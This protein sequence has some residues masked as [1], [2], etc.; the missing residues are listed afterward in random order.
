MMANTT[1]QE[2]IEMYQ[3]RLDK[4][5]IET[6]RLE[7]EKEELSR[8]LQALQTIKKLENSEREQLQ[9]TIETLNQDHQAIVK[10]KDD[11][12]DGLNKEL[13][14]LRRRLW[15]KSSER[16]IPED[17][18]QRKLEFEGLEMT[19]EETNLLN[20]AVEEV[21]R[22]KVTREKRKSINKP[23]RLKLSPDLRREV[24][25]LDDPAEV[26]TGNWVC[27]GQKITEVLAHKPAEIYVKQY[28]RK[29]WAKKET[30]FDVNEQDDQVLPSGVV[31][32]PYPNLPFKKS[33]ADASILAALI[34]GKY[35]DHLPFYRQLEIFKRNNVSI[36]ASTV[37]DWIKNTCDM[38]RALYDRLRELVLSTSYIQVDESTIPIVDKEKSKTIKGYLWSVRA[39]QEKTMFFF[40]DHGSRS[41]KVAIGLLNGYKGALQTD[42]Y[43]A[44]TIFDKKEGVLLLNCWAHARRY[45]ESCLKEDKVRAE[46]ALAQIGM[47]YDIERMADDKNLNFDQRAELRTRLAYPILK[48]FEKWLYKNIEDCVSRP[49][50]RLYKALHYTYTLF[51][52][53]SRYHLD[54][55][56]KLDNN[57]VENQ[58]RVLALGRKNYLFCQNHEAAENAA[59]IYSLLGCCKATNVNPYEWLTDVI[60]QLPKYNSDYSLDLADLLPHNWSKN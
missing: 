51:Y 10:Q 58:Q 42:G 11:I 28:V 34:V 50:G 36:S 15:G 56:Y 9:S 13:E 39:V 26:K 35:A 19:E 12:I 14:Y 57:D 16:Y 25:E 31:V 53:L 60:T 40:Y 17:P 46:Y 4:A 8:Q 49:K 38:L 37:N 5:Y 3:E 43:Q 23:V 20:E 18:L 33:N 7:K 47:L 27:I 29:V 6:L 59:L 52:R 48:A 32:A 54:G 21:T 44:Y 41:Q 45:W 30:S 24:I 1:D 55:R 2:L 22:H